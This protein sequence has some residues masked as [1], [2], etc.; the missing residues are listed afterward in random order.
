MLKWFPCEMHCHTLHSDGKFTVESLMQ[1]AKEYGL[2]G[3]ALTDHNTVSGWD[4]ITEEREKKYVSVLK[5]IE[6]TTFFGHM[7]VTDCKEFVDWRDAVPDNIDE[8][9]AEVKKRGGMVGIAHPYELGSPMCTGCF[10]DYH[11]KKWE[12]VDYIEVWSKPFPPSKSANERAFSLWTGLLDKGYHLAATYGKDWHKKSDE[13]EP[14]GCTYIGTESET[15]T[16]AE[17]KKAVQNGRTSITM[18]PLI[19]LTAQRSDAEYNVGDVWEE[20]KAKIKIE[21]FP[22]TRKEHWEKF[23][24]TLESVRLIRNGRR[25]V[26][27]SKYGGNALSFTLNCE[28]GWYI[29]ELWGKI[30][31]QRYMIGFTSPMY[32]TVKK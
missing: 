30:N 11:V 25:T 14:Y 10:W 13:A 22:N 24:I 32:F 28:P 3:I 18:G 2:S 9:I 21:V 20:G 26:F 27:E 6:W 19:T 15:L 4:E 5:G 7:L 1:T 31:G 12:N 23:N 17:I 29:A 8:K 16:G